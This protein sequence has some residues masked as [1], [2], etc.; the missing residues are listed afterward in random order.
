M[1][2]RT[3]RFKIVVMTRRLHTQLWAMALALMAG[4]VLAGVGRAAD[5]TQGNFERGK[6]VAHHCVQCHGVSGRSNTPGMPNLAGQQADYLVQQLQRMRVSAWAQNGII[7]PDRLGAHGLTGVKRTNAHMVDVLMRMSDVDIGDLAIYF[8]AQNCGVR[9]T[10]PISLPASARRCAA[11]HGANGISD[12]THVPSLAGQDRAYLVRQI[13][14]FK[15]AH[16]G[17]PSDGATARSA[18]IMQSQAKLLSDAEIG[19]V[20]TYYSALPCRP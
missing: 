12:N 9:G 8:A 5:L 18:R 14:A 15:V 20:A 19:T 10:A 6:K 16:K 3:E 17:V 11:C 4:A 7:E 2:D 1:H 13:N